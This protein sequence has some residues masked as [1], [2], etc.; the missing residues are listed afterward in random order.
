[1]AKIQFEQ[2]TMTFGPPKNVKPH[3]NGYWLEP[4]HCE[5]CAPQNMRMERRRCDEHA[6]PDPARVRPCPHERY[7]VV[8]IL[9]TRASRILECIACEAHFE[10]PEWAFQRSDFRELIPLSTHQRYVP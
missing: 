1:M 2:K 3:R 4:E 10:I 6:G 5:I 7:K 9:S 8:H